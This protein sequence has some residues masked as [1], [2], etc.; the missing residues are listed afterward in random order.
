MNR[1]VKS[2]AKTMG[3]INFRAWGGTMSV[4]L[5]RFKPLALQMPPERLTW[6]HESPRLVCTPFTFFLFI[7]LSQHDKKEFDDDENSAVKRRS[8]SNQADAI[9]LKESIAA[10]GKIIDLPWRS[11]I[12]RSIIIPLEFNVTV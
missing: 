2:S 5:V 7:F 10:L 4:W 12:P 11:A 9:P 3:R 8:T 6:P 1:V